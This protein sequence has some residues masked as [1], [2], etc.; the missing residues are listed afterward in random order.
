MELHNR[1]LEDSVNPVPTERGV[2][3]LTWA[4]ALGYRKHTETNFDWTVYLFT[5]QE[6]GMKYINLELSNVIGQ[7][8]RTMVQL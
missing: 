7:F 6:V 5:S 4:R 2:V 8:E 1:M 3:E